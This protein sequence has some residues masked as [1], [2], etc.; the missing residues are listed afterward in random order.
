MQATREIPLRYLIPRLNQII[1]AVQ[2]ISRDFP[3][4][5]PG[6]ITTTLDHCE[7]DAARAAQVLLNLSIKEVCQQGSERRQ[8]QVRA[9]ANRPS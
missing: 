6:V 4:L 8:Q 1:A 3:A 2:D 9:V 5:D 7:Y